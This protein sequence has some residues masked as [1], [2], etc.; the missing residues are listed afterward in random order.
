M[1]LRVKIGIKNHVF[2]V[3]IRKVRKCISRSPESTRLLRSIYCLARLAQSVE[4][5]T[6]NLGVVGSSLRLRNFY[7]EN[8]TKTGLWFFMTTVFGKAKKLGS[9][10]CRYEAI[11]N[12]CAY[13]NQHKKNLQNSRFSGWF[14][15]FRSNCLFRMVSWLG[16]TILLN[17]STFA[18]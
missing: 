18:F 13:R 9:K 16:I 1:K 2:R 3:L 17:L 14:K 6:L 12:K 5:E 7:F 10:I 15:K 4:H 11:Q 8:K